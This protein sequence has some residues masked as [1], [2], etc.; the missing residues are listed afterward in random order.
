MN[1][2]E[3]LGDI[4]LMQITLELGCFEAISW[5]QDLVRFLLSRKT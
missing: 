3:H 1:C 5:L 4:G 2:Q